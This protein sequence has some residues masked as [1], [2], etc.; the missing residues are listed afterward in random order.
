MNRNYFIKSCLAGV[1]PAVFAFCLG[2]G[3]GDCGMV[4]ISGIGIYYVL[5]KLFE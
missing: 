2:W 5:S 3:L 1:V 4:L